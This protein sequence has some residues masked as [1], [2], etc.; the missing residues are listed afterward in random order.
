VIDGAF[1]E[2]S[3]QGFELTGFELTG[4]R[5][6]KSANCVSAHGKLISRVLGRNPG[7]APPEPKAWDKLCND[8]LFGDRMKTIKAGSFM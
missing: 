3:S 1:A 7:T 6:P 8:R 2:A 4:L 5:H